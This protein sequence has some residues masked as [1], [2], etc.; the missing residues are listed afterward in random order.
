MNYCYSQYLPA[1]TVQE[2][3]ETVRCP[4]YSWFDVLL[5]VFW[6]TVRLD[7]IVGYTSDNAAMVY[8]RILVFQC[9]HTAAE[10]LD[11]C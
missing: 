5:S 8:L 10:V 1:E 9:H 7:R 4:E 3:D 2:V 6:V 11:L